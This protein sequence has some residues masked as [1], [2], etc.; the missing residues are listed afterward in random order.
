VGLCQYGAH[1]MALQG[2]SCEAILKHYYAGI[3]LGPLVQPSAVS[4][5]PSTGP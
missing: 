4:Y 1:G 3:E 5:Q 2:H